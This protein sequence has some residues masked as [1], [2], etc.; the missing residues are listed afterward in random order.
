MWQAL[1]A[2]VPGL[3]SGNDLKLAQSVPMYMPALGFWTDLLEENMTP[4]LI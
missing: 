4:L 2:Q 1:K 3:E